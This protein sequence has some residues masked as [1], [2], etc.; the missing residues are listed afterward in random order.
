MGDRGCPLQGK[1]ALNLLYQRCQFPV[2]G[3]AVGGSGQ[4]GVKI[5]GFFEKKK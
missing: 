4:G 2:E 1:T 5:C 3:A